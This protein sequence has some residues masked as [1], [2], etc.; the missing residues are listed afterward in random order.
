VSDTEAQIALPA[1][2]AG[3]YGVTIP[4]LSNVAAAHQKFTV[5]APTTFAPAYLAAVGNRG[6]VIHNAARNVLF[7]V[8][9]LTWTLERYSI[10]AGGLVKDRSLVLPWGSA[11]G[12]SLNGDTLY[13]TAGDSG[14]EERS[15]D[16]LEL[17]GSWFGN[18]PLYNGVLQVTNDNRV[19]FNGRLSYFDAVR[20]RFSDAS[21]SVPY[22]Q[23]YA[24]ADGSR[25]FSV[26]DTNSYERNFSRYDPNQG[27]FEPFLNSVILGPRNVALSGDGK[28]VV[29]NMH[30]VYN[31]LD[32]TEAGPGSSENGNEQQFLSPDGTRLYI[33]E[34][35]FDPLRLAKIKV[36]D[37][38]NRV[39]LG[40]IVLPA[41]VGVCDYACY[42]R[43]N[44]AMSADGKA[45]FWAANA[46][47]AVIP[48]PANLLPAPAAAPRLRKSR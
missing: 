9:Q 10:T 32:I 27:G 20:K 15:P 48:I 23:H 2:A 21:A 14:I 5:A 1:M 37:V 17:R 34:V 25:M 18:T 8:D 39:Q 33:P 43:G 29:S 38:V 13:T 4:A 6:M 11:I 30:V 3:S 16:T 31:A 45:F 36:I 12:Q 40:D 46:G 7:M 35:A 26:P 22:G 19:W 47:I 44:F 28:S 41:G 24:S 42:F